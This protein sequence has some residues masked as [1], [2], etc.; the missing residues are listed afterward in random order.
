[1][2][3]GWESVDWMHLAEDTNQWRVLV[4]TVMSLR[5]PQKEGNLLTE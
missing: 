2:E 4:N 5:V 1:M 3:M